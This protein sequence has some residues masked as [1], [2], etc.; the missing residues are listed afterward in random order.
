MTESIVQD[1]L[2]DY[3]A[4]SPVEVHSFASSLEHDQEVV[5]AIYNVLEERSKYQDLIDPVC[6]QLFSFYRSRE[7]ELQRFTLQFLPTLI[8]VYLNSVAHGD[9]KSC[10]SVETLLIGLYNLEVVDERGQ[11]KVVSFRLPSLAQAS[12]YH[13]PMSLAPASLTES[14]LRRLEECNTKLVS[15]G[16]LPQVE[17]LNAQNRLKVMTAL[18]FIYNR[19]LSLLHKSALE[20]L[21]KVSS[22]LVTQGFTKPGHHQRSSYGSDSSFVPRLLP[23]I[24]VSAQLLL[25]LTHATYFAMFNDFGYLATQAL[26]DT[27][28]RCCHEGFPDVLLV[29]GAIRNSLRVNPSGQPGDGPMGISVALSP[30]TTT[31]TTVAKSMITNASFRTKKLPDDIPIQAAKDEAGGEGKN[32]SSITEEQEEERLTPRGKNLP[33]L[34]GFP[35]LGKRRGA[36]NGAPERGEVRRAGSRN[37]GPAPDGDDGRR[38]GNGP[39]PPD[40]S[41]G[42]AESAGS[43]SLAGDPPGAPGAPGAP[44]CVDLSALDEPGKPLDM[45]PHASLQIS[46]V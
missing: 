12:I 37:R 16:P 19:Q 24:P 45:P 35:G 44:E 14:A 1:W 18:L 43:E 42:S 38:A 20:H 26:E 2:V 5:A 23:R 21:C 27:H 4:L 36:R 40:G 29:T 7:A 11:P 33:K 28:Q 25:E 8:F 39:L 3:G 13:E 9:K 32:L 34:P 41:V 6:T 17:A 22:K 30:V 31:V 46:T 10:R 15:W